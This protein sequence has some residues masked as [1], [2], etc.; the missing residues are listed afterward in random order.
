MASSRTSSFDS[1]LAA[2]N[3]LPTRVGVCTSVKN[4][5][6]LTSNPGGNSGK[7]RDVSF[8]TKEWQQYYET[9]F[10]RKKKKVQISR[11]PSS[12]FQSEV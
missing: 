9:V 5:V 2:N 1:D 12:L 7:V 4:G 10:H 8:L 11:S 3:V 6:S